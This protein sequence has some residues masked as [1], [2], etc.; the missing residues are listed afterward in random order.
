MDIFV[1][2]L[3][4]YVALMIIISF[5]IKS[6][7][8]NS[9]TGFFVHNREAPAWQV[10]FSAAGAWMYVLAI[11]LTSE[12]TTKIGMG[13]SIWQI[14]IPSLTLMYFGVMGY[15]LLSKMPEGYTFSEFIQSRY[16]DKRI[17]YFYRIL[18][19]IAA[20]YAVTVSISGFGVIAEYVSKDFDYNIVVIILGLTILC[21]SMWGGIK[22]SFRTDVVQVSLLLFVG[23]VFAIMAIIESGGLPTVLSNWQLAKPSE[24]LGTSTMMNPGLVLLILCAGSIMADNGAWQKVLALGDKKKIAHV[25]V[26]AGLL[27]IICYTAFTLLA[28]SIFSLP[29]TLGNPKT[30]NLQVIEYIVGYGGLLLFTIAILSKASSTSDASLNSAGSVMANDIFPNKDPLFVSRLTMFI[31][32]SIAIFIAVL[33][34]DLW[35]LFTTFGAIR[36]ISIAPTVYALFTD[37]K[38]N[39][40]ILFMSMVVAIIIGTASI[41]FKWM[42]SLTLSLTMIGIPLLAILYTSILNKINSNKENLA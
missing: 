35:I 17:S 40:N 20:V 26:S 10:V 31:V 2:A 33:K 12:F 41:T 25:Y 29:L 21:Y 5:S 32:M 30:A 7:Y 38:F 22:A 24:I 15:Q 14:I 6:T 9:K 27:M 1:V 3:T 8:R 11:I 13:A 36:L 34:I 28:A 42:D 19:L 23:G 18:H 4:I 16:N 37:H 39:T